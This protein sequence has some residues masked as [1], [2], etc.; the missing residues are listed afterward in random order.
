MQAADQLCITCVLTALPAQEYLESDIAVPHL[1]T[2]KDV[3]NYGYS[4]MKLCNAN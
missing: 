1:K 2:K 4:Y 3:R